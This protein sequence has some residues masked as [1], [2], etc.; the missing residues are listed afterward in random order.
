MVA[1]NKDRAEEYRRSALNKLETGLER[2]QKARDD[3]VVLGATLLSLHGALEDEVRHTLGIHP[4]IPNDEQE[5]VLDRQRT[6][7]AQLLAMLER[8]QLLSGPERQMIAHAN[9]LRQ[10]FAHG[11]V[12]AG[13]RREVEAYADLVRKIIED[14]RLSK[15]S[16]SSTDPRRLQQDA[17]AAAEAGAVDDLL[18][19]V[20]QINS[21]STRQDLL[22][23]AGQEALQAGAFRDV[24]K[25]APLIEAGGWL[26]SRDPQG[27]LKKAGQQAIDAGAMDDLIKIVEQISSSSMRRELLLSAGQE[28]LKAGAFR[29][30]A[31]LA[32]LAQRGWLSNY[33][34]QGLLKMAA[35]QAIEAGAADDLLGIVANISNSSTSQALLWRAGQEALKAGAF[36]DVAR[37]APLIKGGWLSSYDPQG[38]LKKAGYQAIEAGATGD[39]LAIAQLITNT[40]EREN[41]LKE[42]GKRALRYK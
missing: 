24:A 36:C 28:A 32:P 20:G 5:E 3:P 25:V 42:A 38:L 27:L 11:D 14:S 37:V 4:A 22:W 16:S 9:T 23:L 6:Q 26:S 40:Y 29:D 41:L 8:Q 10:P 31:K 13:S 35:E 17:R 15:Q 2:L 33:D 12:F 30:V 34:L 21:S 19:I 7:W 1:N 39:V 18:R